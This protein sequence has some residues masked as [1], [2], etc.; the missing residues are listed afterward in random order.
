MKDQANRLRQMMLR[1]SHSRAVDT[2]RPTLI[3]V[4]GAKGGVGTST[5]AVNLAVE[6]ARQGQRSLLVDADGDSADAT[7]LCGLPADALED[8]GTLC[9]VLAAR[10]R[11]DEVLRCGPMGVQVVPGAWGDERAAGDAPSRQ[12]RLVDQLRGTGLQFDFVV[13]DIGCGLG[14]VVRRYW[15]AVDAVLM[16]TTPDDVSVMDAYAAIKLLLAGASNA[17]LMSVVNRTD[18]NGAGEEVTQRLAQSC[19]RFLGIDMLAG[20]PVPEDV[21]VRD[22]ALLRLPFVVQSPRAAATRAL[23]RLA[24]TTLS[25][26]APADR[27]E[28]RRMAQL[29]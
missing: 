13:L 3:G 24:N 1:S 16:V 15:Q 25:M 19:K 4:A 26:L 9:D 8:G 20:Q 22:A 10:R 14:N 11:V 28:I 2:A 17:T 29:G 23:E 27:R 6:L 21:A 5:I 12:S 18:R 7:A